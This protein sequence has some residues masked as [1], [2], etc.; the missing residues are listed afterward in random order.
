MYINIVKYMWNF[1][2]ALYWWLKIRLSSRRFS[3]TNISQFKN[4]HS[5]HFHRFLYCSRGN[6]LLRS[7]FTNFCSSPFWYRFFFSLTLLDEIRSHCPCFSFSFLFNIV[8]V[9]HTVHVCICTIL[10]WLYDLRKFSQCE[11]ANQTSGN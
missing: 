7:I 1:Y 4:E 2:F 9:C 6:K 8:H 3:K 11:P 10:L 5:L